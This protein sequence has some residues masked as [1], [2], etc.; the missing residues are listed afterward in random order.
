MPMHFLLS[1]PVLKYWMLRNVLLLSTHTHT[2]CCH[3]ESHQGDLNA[4]VYSY[5][6]T[7]GRLINKF[8]LEKQSSSF[9]SW[10]FLERGCCDILYLYFLLKH[11]Y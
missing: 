5:H 10:H 11:T 4:A 3:L 1:Q 7:V 8:C 6:T 2:H 9:K